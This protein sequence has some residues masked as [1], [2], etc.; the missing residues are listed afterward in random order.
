MVKPNDISDYLK[1]IGKKAPFAFRKKLITELRQNISEYV[2]EHP[3]CS[4]EDVIN[5]FGTP[6]QFADEYILAMDETARKEAIQ[7]AGLI[8]KGFWLLLL[9]HCL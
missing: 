6:E 5:H 9:L 4:I 8:K 7:K 2:D 1:Q 3:N